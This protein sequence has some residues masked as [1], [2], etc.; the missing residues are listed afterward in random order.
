MF[1]LAGIPAGKYDLEC[2]FKARGYDLDHTYRDTIVRD[3]IVLP[4]STVQITVSLEPKYDM[5]YL[6]SPLTVSSVKP[7]WM[8]YIGV[9][10]TSGCPLEA[11]SKLIAVNGS[12]KRV[13]LYYTSLKG[14]VDIKT[15]DQALE[16]VRLFS[17]HARYVFQDTN[18]STSFIEV[19]P[20]TKE[21]GSGELRASEFRRLGLSR[22]VVVSSGQKFFIDRYVYAYDRNLYKIREQVSPDGEYAI[23]ERQV[24][25]SHVSIWLPFY[26]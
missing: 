11:F 5:V 24:V 1:L 18:A 4:D 22:P 21:P 6:R 10:G 19:T 15:P 14:Y 3:L 23:V 8:F 17:S 25:N 7:G 20:T 13:L 9:Y 26:L 16:F 12:K 2:V